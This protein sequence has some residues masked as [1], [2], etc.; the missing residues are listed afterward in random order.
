MSF[1]K[2]VLIIALIVLSVMLFFIALAM[3]GLKKS[4]GYP[5]E[6]A[7]CPDYW[8]KNN[9]GK[10]TQSPSY[11]T[12][13]AKNDGDDCSEFPLTPGETS[14][15]AKKTFSAACTLEWDGITNIN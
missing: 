14:V 3:R 9:N 10:C 1:Q 7:E 15:E 12:P 11:N 13:T 2:T 8:T 6:I 5:P 4:Q